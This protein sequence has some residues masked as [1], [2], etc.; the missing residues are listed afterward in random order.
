ML[1]MFNYSYQRQH[2]TNSKSEQKQ[3]YNYHSKPSPSRVL[4]N[5][6]KILELTSSASN[7][8]IKKAYRRLA[9]IHHPDRSIHLGE[10]FQK[11]AK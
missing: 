9:K 3:E 7:E 1:A 4:D 10:K 8:E 5:A 2:A 6:Y 11:S